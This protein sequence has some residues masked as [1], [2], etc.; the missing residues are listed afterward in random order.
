MDVRVRFTKYGPIKYV[1]HLDLMRYFQKALRRSGLPLSFTKGFSPHPILSFASPL[2]VGIT[3]EGEYMDFSLDQDVPLSEIRAKLNAEEAY[4][5]EILSVNE[6]KSTKKAMAELAAASYLVYFKKNLLIERAKD[7]SNDLNE[8][9]IS[10]DFLDDNEHSSFSEKGNSDGNEVSAEILRSLVEEKITNASSLVVTKK[11]KKS[12]RQVDLLPL[13]YEI[14]VLDSFPSDKRDHYIPDWEQNGFL[15]S[16]SDSAIYMKVCARSSD[17]LK[18]ELLMEALL[19]VPFDSTT[20]GVHRLDMYAENE[21][22]ELIPLGEA[23]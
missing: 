23:E 12:E 5:I 4:G 20:L 6:R 22:D 1:G 19:G 10:K 15:L 18:P 8:N 7:Q 14:E 17:N 16:E 3:S 11:T 2:G 13:I 9:S 21:A